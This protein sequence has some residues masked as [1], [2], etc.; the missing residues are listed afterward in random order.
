MGAER[1]RKRGGRVVMIT[2]HPTQRN[3]KARHELDALYRNWLS[4]DGVA[5]YHSY[6]DDKRNAAADMAL[7]EYQAAIVYHTYTRVVIGLRETV[8]A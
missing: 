2:Y 3:P 1:T 4:L 7:E 5:E 8:T 6:N